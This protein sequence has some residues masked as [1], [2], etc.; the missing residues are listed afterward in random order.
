MFVI[1]LLAFILFSHRIIICIRLLH[2]GRVRLRRVTMEG[3]SL[4]H[5]IIDH[6]ILVIKMLDYRNQ[7]GVTT[8]WDCLILNSF[9][10]FLLTNSYYSLQKLFYSYF[11]LLL[12]VFKRDSSAGILL[13]S[14]DDTSIGNTHQ[15]IK[16]IP[17]EIY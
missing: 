6:H 17:E 14:L 15:T 9:T 5:Q 2:H 10:I 8:Y 16:L 12:I 11:N 3:P 7:I 1:F 13:G 4:L